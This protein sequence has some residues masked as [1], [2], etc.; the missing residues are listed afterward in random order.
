MGGQVHLVGMLDKKLLQQGQDFHI[1]VDDQQS[2][3][4]QGIQGQKKSVSKTIPRPG[5]Y[6]STRKHSC[7]PDI[8]RTYGRYCPAAPC[9]DSNS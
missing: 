3:H 1:V 7:P 4:V 2:A 5:S 9:A 8:N 6:I